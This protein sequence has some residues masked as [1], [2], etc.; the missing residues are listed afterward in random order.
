MNR[1]AHLGIALAAAYLFA[2]LLSTAWPA[3]F[4]G[5]AIWAYLPS[6]ILL[7]TTLGVLATVLTMTCLVPK[8]GI[9]PWNTT[10]TTH[11]FAFALSVLFG[12]VFVVAYSRLDLLGDGFLYIREIDQAADV[13]NLTRMD[14]AP[15]TFVLIRALAQFFGPHGLSALVLYKAISCLSGLV[16]VALAF[17][18]CRIATEHLRKRVI[19]LIALLTVP[20]LQLFFGYAENYAALHL[21]VMAY[22]FLSF[23]A[24][25]RSKQPIGAAVCLAVLIP[26]HLSAVLLLPSLA[27]VAF[28]SGTSCRT[29]LS[30]PAFALLT[31]LAIFWVIDFDLAALFARSGSGSNTLSL[32]QDALR[33]YGLLSFAHILDWLNLYLLVAPAAILILPACGWRLVSNADTRFLIVLALPGIAFTFIANPEIGAFRDWDVLSLPAIPLAIWAGLV[34]GERFATA[35]EFRTMAASTWGTVAIHTVAWVALNASPDAAMDRYRDNLENGTLAPHA[36]SY[37]WETLA[38]YHQNRDEIDASSSAFGRALEATPDK[39]RLWNALGMMAAENARYDDALMALFRS[40]ELQPFHGT[41]FN[42]GL[43]CD[44]LGK[45]TETVC[46]Y[47]NAVRLDP[48]HV[49]ALNNLASAYGR[50]GRYDDAVATYQAALVVDPSAPTILNNLGTVFVR[51]QNYVKAEES[52][53]AA[54]RHDPGVREPYENLSILYASLGY[55]DRSRSMSDR[56]LALT[57]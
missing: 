42:I 27:Y 37:G 16:F 35:T 11:R 25:R 10:A 40:A 52:Y 15:L 17:W 6:G 38:V 39:A 44:R 45:H 28:R 12:G 19:L 3:K 14:R 8:R 33:P 23:R 50:V 30:T 56:A 48:G 9:D 57:N 31:A 53:L 49:K 1:L 26:I 13:G 18:F 2:H 24:I 55:K 36:R 21:G 4:W 46:A 5:L 32:E 51:L 29:R 43:I 20:S 7:L 41:W 54:L 22:A 34:F 47:E